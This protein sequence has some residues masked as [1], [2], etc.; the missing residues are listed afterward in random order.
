MLNLVGI[1][2][3]DRV[4]ISDVDDLAGQLVDFR[5]GDARRNEHEA[6]YGGLSGRNHS[7]MIPEQGWRRKRRLQDVQGPLSAG[8]VLGGSEV[9]PGDDSR[10]RQEKGFAVTRTT[11]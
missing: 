8:I 7:G 1:Q 11:T 3:R 5:F 2:H 4:A 6:A 9:L 10:R